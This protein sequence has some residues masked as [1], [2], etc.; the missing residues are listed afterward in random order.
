MFP[1]F[2]NTSLQKSATPVSPP[3]SRFR[4]TSLCQTA[5]W[6]LQT[7]RKQGQARMLLTH[8][9][10]EIDAASEP[11][12]RKRAGPKPTLPQRRWRILIPLVPLALGVFLFTAGPGAGKGPSQ[13]AS[14]TPT[15][16]AVIH[17]RLAAS[18]GT[19]SSSGLGIGAAPDARTA[20]TVP[21]LCINPLNVTCW[22][23]SASQWLAQQ[24][25]NALQPVIAAILNSPLNILTQTPPADTYQNPTVMRWFAAF[26]DVVDLAL[27]SLPMRS[28]LPCGSGHMS[29]LCCRGLSVSHRILR[30]RG[31]CSVLLRRRSRSFTESRYGRP[32]KCS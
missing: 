19:A 1:T 26:L 17:T 28:I 11:Q 18:P 31:E 3:H 21:G 30:R 32:P 8:A 16:Q 14:P 15:G 24:I 2:C 7:V 25:I 6:L 12:A 27:A 5:I 23:Q 20:R 22:L 9:R 10:Q 29:I 4:Y 13:S